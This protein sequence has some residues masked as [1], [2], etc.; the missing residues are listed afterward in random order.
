M[1]YFITQQSSFVVP[2][3]RSLVPGVFMSGNLEILYWQNEGSA[4]LRSHGTHGRLS[5]KGTV[6]AGRDSCGKGR[7]VDDQPSYC[8]LIPCSPFAVSLNVRFDIK[9]G[10][11]FDF[12]LFVRKN[13]LLGPR[14][15][16][17]AGARKKPP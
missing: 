4:G 13:Q 8:H 2:A 5:D 16:L 11:E 1:V 9:C 14:L 6:N 10:R 15:Q 12:R 3:L 7:S 17:F